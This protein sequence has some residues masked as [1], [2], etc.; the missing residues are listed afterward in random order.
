MNKCGIKTS[1]RTSYYFTKYSDSALT[2]DHRNLLE[3]F[4]QKIFFARLT[5]DV[6]TVEK[7]RAV[8]EIKER[9]PDV[10]SC[11]FD[12]LLKKQAQE[13]ISALFR[14]VGPL[15]TWKRSARQRLRTPIFFSINRL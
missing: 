9:D 4:Q 3:I 6:F 12:L 5:K 2:E 8:E 7:N 15:K 1:A 14:P 10:A 13:E 11:F